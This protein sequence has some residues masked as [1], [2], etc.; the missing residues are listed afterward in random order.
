[1]NKTERQFFALLRSGL[2]GSWLD[3]A[4]FANGADWEAILKIAQMQTV[5]GL[6]F[7]GISSLPATL[8]PPA[9][10]MR[11]LYQTIIRIEQSHELL[12]K[13]IAEIVPRFEAEGICPVLLKGQGV[14]QSYP[15][16]VRRQCGD[17]DL[18]VGGACYK[19]A[20]ELA[21]EMGETEAAIESVKHYHFHI[22]DVAVELH[23]IA[24]KLYNPLQNPG[25]QRWTKW[26]LT[27]NNLRKWEV[28]GT[29]VALPAIH[30]D[31]VFIF[32][33]LYRHF[34][35]GGVG[36]RQLCDWVLCLNKFHNTINKPELYKDLKSFGL[37]RA[38]KIFGC[39]A[40][41]CLELDEDRFPFYSTKYRKLEQRVLKS[42]LQTGNFGKYNPERKK[43]P[44]GY[45]AG[46]WHSFRLR[47]QRVA[48]LF[49]IA[50]LSITVFYISAFIT[51]II[52][53]I[54]GK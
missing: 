21:R 27:G 18:Y 39:I 24:D 42:I 32:G 5:M 29:E 43:R 15:N 40:V 46:K 47:N 17:I 50:P 41:N 2:W 3:T 14:A 54:K 25:F 23:R 49:S 30:F 53:I 20:C 45:F 19:K 36:L 37:L 9:T 13:Q 1:M 31:A 48:Q 34:I 33:H 6:V 10:I 11:K 35:N 12:N 51:S 38:W 26:H 52:A 22:G 8:Q 28:N 16:P 44:K 7:D 4:L